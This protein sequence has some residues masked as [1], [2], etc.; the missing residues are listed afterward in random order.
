LASVEQIGGRAGGEGSPR[1]VLQGPAGG[2]AYTAIRSGEE[3]PPEG[4]TVA[5]ARA[6]LAVTLSVLGTSVYV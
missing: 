5:R 4:L 2:E 3:E 1:Y 6:A